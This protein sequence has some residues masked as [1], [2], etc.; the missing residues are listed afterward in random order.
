MTHT[1]IRIGNQQLAICALLVLLLATLGCDRLSPREQATPVVP[2]ASST[3]T[4][5]PSATPIPTLEPTPTATPKPTST[6]RPTSTPTPTPAPSPTPS[7]AELAARHPELA[8]ILNNPEL[9]SA[10]KEF[11]V[12]YQEGGEQAALELARQRGL[13]T[14]EGGIRTT[15]VLD[16]EETGPVVAQL[17]DAGTTVVGAH[18]NQIDV[19]VPMGLIQAQIQ[20]NQPGAIFAQL[21]GLGHVVGVRPP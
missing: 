19:V 13:L 2:P 12:A 7:L 14:P 18:A 6:L 11:L 21:A 4:P 15:L 10:Y 8:P 3:L 20:A 1:Q 9:S 17:E 5:K 16:T